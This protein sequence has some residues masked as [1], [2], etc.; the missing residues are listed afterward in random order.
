MTD[1]PRDESPVDRVLAALAVFDN[2]E[3]DALDSFRTVVEREFL[4]VHNAAEEIGRRHLAEQ[5]EAFV[6]AAE[7]TRKAWMEDHSQ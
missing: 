1:Q 3:R 5:A 4:A 7:A 6:Q 2:N